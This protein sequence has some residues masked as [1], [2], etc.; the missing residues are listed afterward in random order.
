[1]ERILT[2]IVNL[3]DGKEQGNLSPEDR[4]SSYRGGEECTCPN[5]LNPN[6]RTPV[7]LP[8]PDMI[9]Q[10]LWREQHK[11]NID[12]AVKSKKARRTPD[13]VLYGDSITEFFTGTALSFPLPTLKDN[14]KVYEDLLR[15]TD[16]TLY[17]L[18]LGISGD[19]CTNLLYRIQNGELPSDMNPSMIWLLIG[20]NVSLLFSFFVSLRK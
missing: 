13:L 17:G 14:I 10:F 8:L 18:G 1:M 2:H 15:N 9:R 3:H 4:C 7:R 16:N 19:I 20:S 11:A 5:P 12:R 6:S